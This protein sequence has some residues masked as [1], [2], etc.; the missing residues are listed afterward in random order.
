MRTAPADAQELRRHRRVGAAL[1]PDLE[2]LAG[3]QGQLR[4]RPRGRRRRSSPTIPELRA[5]GARANGSSSAGPCG[6][7]PARPASGSSW[8]S[9]P[10]CPPPTTPTRSPRPSP[11]SPG[12]STSTTTRWCWSHARALLTSTPRGRHRLH[13]RR[14]PRPGG[15]PRRGRARPWTSASR[16]RSCCWASSTSSSTTTRPPPSSRQ[17]IDG[18]PAGSYLVQCLT[19]RTPTS[20]DVAALERYRDRRRDALGPSRS[21]EQ[22]EGACTTG[23]D[24]GR[25]RVSCRPA[26]G[27][28]E[29]NAFGVGGGGRSSS[30]EF[31]F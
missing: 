30:A 10:A 5:V 7:W 8:T 1:G 12:S 9:A 16:S 20:D 23:F 19:A 11:R 31:I 27:G 18:L 13:R 4:R 26:K 25:S 14:P 2:L 15:D 29:A 17:L 6:T 21:H 3:R 24:P 22:I 28:P